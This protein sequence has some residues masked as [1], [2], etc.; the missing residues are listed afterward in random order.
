[1]KQY[2]SHAEY[3]I[4]YI[5]LQY[6]KP[7]KKNKTALKFLKDLCNLCTVYLFRNSDIIDNFE[8]IT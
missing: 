3:D 8:T 7:F 4:A 5:F 1:M 2:N 6:F